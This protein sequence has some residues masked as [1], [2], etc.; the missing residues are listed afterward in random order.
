MGR[1][2]LVERQSLAALSG[3]RRPGRRLLLGLVA[4]LAGPLR[5][6]LATLLLRP[7]LRLRLPALL[8]V[9]LLALAHRCSSCRMNSVLEALRLSLPCWGRVGW[10]SP[11]AST[12]WRLAPFRIVR[13]RDFTRYRKSATA[14][15]RS[16]MT[17]ATNRSRIGNDRVTPRRNLLRLSPA[18]GGG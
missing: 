8:A 18:C 13:Q 11:S 6:R 5:A 17:R 1:R 3:L 7:L 15:R 4:L 14:W 10:G 9:L 16:P 12:I 2:F